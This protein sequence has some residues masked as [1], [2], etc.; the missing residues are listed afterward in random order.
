LASKP[1]RAP[2]KVSRA[3]V[4]EISGEARNAFG[5]QVRAHRERLGM[6]QDALADILGKKGQSYVSHIEHGR[7]NLTLDTM[8]L[9]A[10]ALGF[11]LE[12]IF[13]PRG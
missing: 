8:A 9:L 4:A 1:S 10:D 2:R 12:V 13:R 6:T 7:Q 3:R 11:E 5:R